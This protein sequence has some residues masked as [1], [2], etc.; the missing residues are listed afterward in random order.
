MPRVKTGTTRRA[1][2]KKLLAS[3]KGYR[4]TKSRL[5]KVA[6]EASLHAGEYAFAHR[7]DRKNDFRR[8]W[9]TRINAGLA[10]IEGAPKYSRFVKALK[11]KQITLDRKILAFFAAKQPE[12]F[13]AVVEKVK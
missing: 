13:K 6:K 1:R 8:L 5:V 4:M 3:T 2:H 12:V 9:I 11:D 7:K 10:G